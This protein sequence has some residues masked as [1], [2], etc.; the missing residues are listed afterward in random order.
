MNK[1]LITISFFALMLAVFSC[2]E[3]KANLEESSQVRVF[4]E[5][6]A[7]P[8]SGSIAIAQRAKMNVSKDG[9]YPEMAFEFKEHDFGMINRGDIVTCFFKFEN[10]GDAD[11]IISRAVGSCGCT[12]PEYPKTPLK[13]G[14]KAKIKVTFN[15]GGKH[16]K[17]QK[18]VTILTNTKEATEILLV[19]AEI[20]K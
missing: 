17:Q 2:N 20:K 10:T 6:K 16:G 3:K 7:I 13:P 15:S 19:K 8:N 11:L 12:V 1:K 4:E 5:P 9:K 18:S 14:E